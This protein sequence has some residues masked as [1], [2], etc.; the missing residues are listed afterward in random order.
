M[1]YKFLFL[2]DLHD[3]EDPIE[4]LDYFEQSIQ[5][6]LEDVTSIHSACVE[7]VSATP[8]SWLNRNTYAKPQD[9]ITIWDWE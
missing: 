4:M 7:S 3:D 1:I 9:L 5:E 6:N 8:I 2:V